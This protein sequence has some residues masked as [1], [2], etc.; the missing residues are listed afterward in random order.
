MKKFIVLFLVTGFI[1]LTGMGSHKSSALENLSPRQEETQMA[2]EH[3][4]RSAE[5]GAGL[6]MLYESGGGLACREATPEEAL[7]LSEPDRVEQLHTISRSESQ[8]LNVKDKG[9]QIVLRATQQLER[10]P[11]A[12]TAFL[13]AS[14][15]WEDRIQ[16]PI[17][18]IIDVDFGPTLFGT[19]FAQGSIG[20]SDA[21]EVTSTDIYGRVRSQLITKASSEQELAVYQS[22]PASAL[23]TDIGTTTTMRG[24]SANARALG[25]LTLW[26]TRPVRRRISASHPQSVSIRTSNSIMTQPMASTATRLISMPWSCTK[27]DTCWDSSQRLGRENS[28]ANC[29]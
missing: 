15:F 4:S 14:A 16:T 5:P 21:Q 29:R 24:A 20:A 23:P 27:S 19:P 18:I 9:L 13:R 8:S 17:T 2:T 26:Q 22:L 1:N 12:K 28:T 11:E 6:F 25:C 10:F 7:S 3:F